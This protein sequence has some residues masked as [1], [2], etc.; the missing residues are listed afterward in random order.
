MKNTLLAKTLGGGV[1]ESPFNS[2]KIVLSLATIS[3]LASY[4][5]ATTSGTCP[6]STR[7]SSDSTNGNITISTLC[8]NTVTLTPYTTSTLTITKNGTLGNTHSISSLVLK[9]DNGS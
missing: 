8:T 2:K 7:S 3:F 1:K 5:N 6:T 4:A 9:P